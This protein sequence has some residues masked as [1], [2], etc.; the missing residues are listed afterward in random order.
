MKILVIQST[1]SGVYYH[2][3]FTPHYT[4]LDSGDEFKD[5]MVAIVEDRHM[6]KLRDLL[7][8]QS[9]D[10]I[11]YSVSLVHPK[12]MV[13]QLKHAKELATIIS[14]IRYRDKHTKIILDIDDRYGKERKD[15][16]RAIKEADA[17]TVTCDNLKDFFVGEGKKACYVIENGIDSK[18]KQWQIKERS[19]EEIVFGYLG[20]TKHEEDL[21]EMRYDFSTRKLHVVCEEYKDILS[22]D[23]IGGL[24]HWSDYAYAYDKCDVAL[25][26]IQNN[27]F[28][29]SKSNLKIIEAGF[30]KKAIICSK[31]EPYTRDKSLYPAIDLI[32]KKKSWKRRIEE[33][34]LEEAI[35]R[36]EELYKLV[37]PYEIRNMNKK[38]R[39]IYQK[40]INA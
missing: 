29:K 6:H 20:S 2:R 30:K 22:V 37:Q 3:Q 34:T 28:N 11:Q 36:G 26:P 10:I 35:Q 18:E 39:E 13:Y 40:I 23:S 31:I 5:D 17:L 16:Y 19:G 33:Y 9:F 32:P 15:V 24:S 38:R 7:D 21:K 14:W 12:N 4:W 1:Q 27:W 8:N 25:A